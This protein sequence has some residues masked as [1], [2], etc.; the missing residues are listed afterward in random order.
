MNRSAKWLLIVTT[1]L[2]GFSLVN[3][4]RFGKFAIRY[5]SHKY[6]IL[7]AVTYLWFLRTTLNI[8]N[9]MAT[10]MKIIVA[11]IVKIKKATGT[12]G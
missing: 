1:T 10:N 3:C 12:C 2:D 7:L 5:L 11:I 9:A 4:R 6:T 8:I